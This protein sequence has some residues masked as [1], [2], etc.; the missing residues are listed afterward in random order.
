MLFVRRVRCRF[1]VELS[2]VRP[3][4][5]LTKER[6]HTQTT[7]AAPHATISIRY[8]HASLD[9]PSSPLTSPAAPRQAIDPRRLD[10]P[11]ASVP[12]GLPLLPRRLSSHACFCRRWHPTAGS[13]CRSPSCASP[14][15]AEPSEP[16]PHLPT[17]RAS[18]LHAPPPRPARD[19]T[20]SQTPG[21]T[22]CPA[23]GAR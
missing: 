4:S 2:C 18:P 22:P 9:S 19:P 17:R 14:S 5:R 10:A 11:G 3:T 16:E 20:R 1:H 13:R 21:P 12:P 6:L 15:P 8:K 7:R 23:P